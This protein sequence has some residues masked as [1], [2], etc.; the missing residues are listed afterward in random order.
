MLVAR[1]LCVIATA[2]GSVRCCLSV[3]AVASRG[4]C[5]RG[6]RLRASVMRHGHGHEEPVED[7]DER[8]Q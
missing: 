3:I 8:Q 7:Q 4:H 6:Y 5:R 1:R 2:M